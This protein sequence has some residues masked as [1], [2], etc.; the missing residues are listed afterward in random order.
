[1]K[2]VTGMVVAG[3]FE[4]AAHW[5][6]LAEP[7]KPPTVLRRIGGYTWGCL[8]ILLGVAVATDRP[9]TAKAAAITVAA[10][11]ATVA[12]YVADHLLNVWMRRR[13]YGRHP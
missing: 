11:T 3:L 8:G 12:A 10:G 4:L 1:M 2:L 13:A 9:T 5:F 7:H 6:P